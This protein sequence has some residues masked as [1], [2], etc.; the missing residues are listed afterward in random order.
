V[1]GPPNTEL[2][3]E[4]PNAG[5]VSFNSLFDSTVF[6]PGGSPCSP[7]SVKRPLSLSKASRDV[8]EHERASVEQHVTMFAKELERTAARLSR[9]PIE[10]G[11]NDVVGEC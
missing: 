4:A 10:F 1:N 5:F 6:R 8:V 2:S 11:R 7:R 9:K 3:C